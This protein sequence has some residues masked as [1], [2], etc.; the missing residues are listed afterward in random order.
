MEMLEI[1]LMNGSG[2]GIVKDAAAIHTDGDLHARVQVWSFEGIRENGNFNILLRKR[3]E[4]CAEAPGLFTAVCDGHVAPGETFEAAANRLIKADLNLDPPADYPFTFD[5]FHTLV[6]GSV[7]E[8]T[9]DNEVCRVFLL[10]S[11]TMPY[12]FP[13]RKQSGELDW[14]DAQ[15]LLQSLQRGDPAYSIDCGLYEKLLD[16]YAGVRQYTIHVTDIWSAPGEGSYAGSDEWCYHQCYSFF[17][18]KEAAM[19]EGQW[20]VRS[21]HDSTSPYLAS[22]TFWLT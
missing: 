3:S 2:T 4:E 6:E 13:S 18:T 9:I 8:Q 22:V 15:E 21:F 20:H 1:C 5:Y 16:V 12:L 10:D 17:G 19:R 11:E 7:E 14:V